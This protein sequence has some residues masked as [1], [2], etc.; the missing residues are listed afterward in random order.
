MGCLPVIESLRR[1]GWAVHFLL[2]CGFWFVR[3]SGARVR[4]GMI[5]C[6][7]EVLER[8]R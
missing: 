8:L 6:G 2:N 1:I 7:F 5:A 3:M 4:G